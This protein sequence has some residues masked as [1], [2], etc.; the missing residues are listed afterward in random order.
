MAIYTKFGKQDTI[1]KFIRKLYSDI[2]N[3]E[4]HA[5][6]TYSDKGCTILQCQARRLR[7]FD[8][9]L[10]CVQTYYPHATPEYLMHVLLT[11]VIKHEGKHLYL[12]MS[13]CT[14]ISRIRVYYYTGESYEN[15]NCSKYNSK[16]SWMNLLEMIKLKTTREIREYVKKYKHEAL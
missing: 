8:D 5:L 10:E 3:G 15:I 11:I 2:S 12:Y 6:A 13:N 9:L 1:Y 14:T 4:A 7:S 16:W